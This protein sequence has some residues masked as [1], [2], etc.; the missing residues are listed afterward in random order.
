MKITYDKPTITRKELESVLDSLINNELTSGDTV[1]T[2]ESAICS[3][4][5]LKYA[6]TTNSSVSAYH[7]IFEAL[8]ISKDDE[9]IVPSFFDQ[10]P[11]GGALLSGGTII[12]VDSEENSIFP[13]IS[14]IKEKINSDTKA[15]IIG[16]TF[17]FHYDTTELLKLNIPIIEDISHAIGTE[18]NDSPV[19]SKSTFTI[20][21]FAPSMI[22]TT[23]NGGMVLTNNSKY[24]STMR[25]KR[26]VAKELI[27]FDYRMTDF[28]AAMG[29]SQLLKLKKLLN[30]RREIAVKFYESIRT[31][32][33]KPILIYNENYA[34]QS[35][36]VIFDSLNSRV[37]KFWK[38]NQI[39]IINP[40]QYPLH[41]LMNKKGYDF[42]NTD[43]LSKKL[44][45]LPLYPT[46]TKKEIEKIS[47]TISSFI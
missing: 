4:T 32:P 29:I 7:L 25:D 37:E 46:L 13:S 18:N 42:P 28:Q 11:M 40:Y 39:E 16:H 43:R 10:A 38:K 6:V 34:Y 47:K 26:G 21:S 27:H 33:H 44:F 22:I 20:I 8:S 36:P 17:G 12:P 15:I 19:G 3:L 2:F 31:T 1:K 24:Y 9:I 5:D 30:R 35:F 45:S 41:I 23:G 14:Q